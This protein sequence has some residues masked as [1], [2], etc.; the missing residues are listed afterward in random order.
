VYDKNAAGLAGIGVAVFL[1][2]AAAAKAFADPTLPAFGSAVYNV[3]VANSAI[4]GG[5]PASTSS[6]NNAAAINAYISY[7]SSQGGGTVEIPA[8]TFLSNEITLQSNVNLQIDGGGILRDANYNT[9]LIDTTG[10]SSNIEISGGGI[11][12]GAAT[13]SVG[14]NK[15]IDLSKVTNLE[16]TGVSIENSGNEHLV[17][18]NDTN[19]TINGVTIADPGTLAANGG[20]YLANTDGID[21]WGSNFLIENCNISDGDDDIVAKTA[22]G[23]VSN[24]TI[25]N[26]T[27]GAGHGISVGGGSSNGL[28][29]MTVSNCTL[30]G[31]TYGLRFKAQDSEG[32]DSGGGAAHP[33][34]NVTFS[35]I[36]MTNVAYP[37]EIDSFY[38]GGDNF[39]ESPFAPYYPSTPTAMDAYAP[40]WQ[41]I[42]FDNITATNA[43]YAGL[44][45]GL[46][47]SP[48]SLSGLSFDNVNISAYASMEL[49]YA[50][51]VDLSGLTVEVPYYDPYADASPVNG[52]YAYGLTDVTVPEPAA[53]GAFA[54]A[55]LTLGRRRT[56]R[57]RACPT[58]HSVRVNS[59]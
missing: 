26:D 46:N 38:N 39:P 36:S 22:S 7:C 6:S 53:M 11:I 21:Y 30:N 37:L 35:N 45:F 12:D 8:G 5:K 17:T 19:V 49:W 1:T 32:S 29:N 10:T 54:L 18:E 48:D 14:G 20:N 28:S 3:A 24:V 34:Q 15:L 41:N 27:I 43:Y 9:T 25:T 50:S 56:M 42:S 58:R 16:V 33:V 40:V 31:T 51:D 55:G 52:V 23:P 57:S 2:V 59:C 44:I 47:T 13:T 4:N